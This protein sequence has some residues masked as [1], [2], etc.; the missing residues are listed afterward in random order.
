MVTGT[1]LIVAESLEAATAIA[2]GCPVYEFDGS[3]EVRAIVA[4]G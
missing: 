2:L 4:R 3:V 1:M